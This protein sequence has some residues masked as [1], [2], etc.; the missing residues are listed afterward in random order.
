[1]WLKDTPPGY[2]RIID[3]KFDSDPSPINDTSM[4]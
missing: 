2:K 4:C 3:I 1:M